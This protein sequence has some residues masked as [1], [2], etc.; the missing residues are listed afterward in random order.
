MDV[1]AYKDLFETQTNEE[2]G[3]WVSFRSEAIS[4]KNELYKKISEVIRE[5]D[6][7]EDSAYNFTLEALEAIEEITQA[8][9]PNDAPL[10]EQLEDYE[11]VEQYS[12]APVYTNELMSWLSKRA[13]YTFIEE[14]FSTFGNDIINNGFQSVVSIAYSEAWKQHYFKVLEAVRS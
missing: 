8:H 14:A 2:R 5:S 11:I 12:E 3:T 1:Q 10:E 9:D 7:D 6:L 4:D 13:N